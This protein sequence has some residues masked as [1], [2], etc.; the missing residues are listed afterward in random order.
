MITKIKDYHFP[1]TDLAKRIVKQ[2]RTTDLIA[3]NIFKNRRTGKTDFLLRDLKPLAEKEGIKV[4]YFSFMLNQA[5]EKIEHKFLRDFVYFLKEEH[6]KHNKTKN[7]KDFL[8][9]L[10]KL[11]LGVAINEKGFETNFDLEFNNLL[12]DLKSD[13][14]SLRSL[15][16]QISLNKDDRFLL[17]LDEFQDLSKNKNYLNFCA[18]LRTAINMNQENIKVIFTGSSKNKLATF[19]NDYHQPFYNFGS[20]LELEDFDENFIK[21]IISTYSHNTGNFLISFE[22]VNEAFIQTNFSPYYVTETLRR[23]EINIKQ[24]FQ[25]I[26][27]QLLIEDR[28]IMGQTLIYNKIFNNLHEIE[29]WILFQIIENKNMFSI[30]EIEQANLLT[31]NLTLNKSKI[32]YY[33][34][35]LKQKDLINQIDKKNYEI[36]DLSF[37]EWLKEKID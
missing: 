14:F 3:Y 5:D 28:K 10:S 13:G 7:L 37:A 31:P 1:R 11:K 4:F 29:K 17:L 16:N 22:E 8:S 2:L 27:K 20:S 36:N 33:I 23:L 32:Q 18:D 25:K 21:H 30:L 6:L 26:F 24:S 12:K 34:K 35:K 9:F 15:F 19:F